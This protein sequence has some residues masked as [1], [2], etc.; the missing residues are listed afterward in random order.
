[1]GRPHPYFLGSFVPSANFACG[2]VKARVLL[3]ET[4]SSSRGAPYETGTGWG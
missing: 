3:P 4:V 2:I 1:M